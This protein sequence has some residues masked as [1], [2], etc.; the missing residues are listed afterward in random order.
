MEPRAD[1]GDDGSGSA[2]R[3]HTPPAAM[4]PRADDG[5]DRSRS[6]TTPHRNK[7]AMEPRADDGDERRSTP[8]TGGASWPQ[9]SPVLMTG[10][11]HRTVI[12]LR[13]QRRAAM[14]PRA[15]DGDDQDPWV[16]WRRPCHAAMEPRADDGDD[17]SVLLRLRV[18]VEP[19]WSP[20]LMTGTT[21]I[22]P[23][24]AC[25]GQSAAMEPRADDGDDRR[26]RSGRSS[27]RT[28]R[29]GAP[30]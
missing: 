1:D 24:P 15:D 26:S 25:A 22:A 10:T 17:H 23:S 3:L 19:Q 4:E 21:W 30:C 12:P 18:L 14:E 28:R 27:S 7:A 11:T 9:W 20:V 16:H 8:S 29:N 6:R 2:S 13:R 5:D